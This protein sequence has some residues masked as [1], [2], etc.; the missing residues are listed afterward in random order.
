MTLEAWALFCV[1]E[2]L[3]C[4]NPGPSALLV[5]SL[6]LTRGR[7]AGLVA[8]L[9]V[10]AAN[11][12]Y[13]ALSATGLVALHTLSAEA[14]TAIKWLGAAYLIWTGVRMVRRSFGRRREIDSAPVA[15]VSKR[16]SFAQ[17]FVAQG[18]N[19]N[20]LVYF[21]AILPQFIDPAAGVAGQVTILALS[22][23]AIELAILSLYA[24]L[25]SRA[26][27]GAAPRLRAL[28]ERLGGGLLI[29]AGAG[30]AALRRQ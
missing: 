13:F 9:G 27:R 28:I 26:G 30:L 15:G 1:T 19:P 23:C 16:R 22:S 24:I 11:A 6:G 14:F 8:A 12:V 5:L 20:L 2:F 3:L 29:G 17:G 25:A 4:L 18:A 10:L 7:A 21:T